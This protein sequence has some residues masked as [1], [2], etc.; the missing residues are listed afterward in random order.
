MRF[1]EGKTHKRERKTKG[2]LKSTVAK[3]HAESGFSPLTIEFN[4]NEKERLSRFGRIKPPRGRK[5]PV[6]AFFSQLKSTKHEASAFA[7]PK[8][9]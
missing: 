4:S 3:Q 8:K 5:R 6:P 1:S 9:A 7:F 2:K